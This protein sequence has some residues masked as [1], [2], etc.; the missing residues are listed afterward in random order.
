MSNYK[1]LNNPIEIGTRSALILTALESSHTLEEL[2][3]LD[4]ALIYSG[5]FGG[6]DN[7]HPATPNHIAEIAHRREFLPDALAFFIKKGLLQTYF[8]QAGQTFEVNE[9]T[10]DFVSCLNTPYH[11]KTWVRLNW[12][13]ENARDVINRNLL[14]MN[15]GQ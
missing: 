4:F 14:Q 5:D 10:I 8:S 13:V 9:N 3:K 11:Q 7:L 2:V 12:L 15:R 1:S 6:P